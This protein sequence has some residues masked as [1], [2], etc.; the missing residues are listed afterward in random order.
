MKLAAKVQ[1]LKLFFVSNFHYE[2]LICKSLTI[3]TN[4]IVESFT[5]K[6]KSVECIGNY[7]FPY[8]KIKIQIHLFFIKFPINLP[9]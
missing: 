3:S 1:Y 8:P 2:Y 6:I 4:K 7:Y 9:T 5:L